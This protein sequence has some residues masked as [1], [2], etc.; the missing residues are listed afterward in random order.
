MQVAR[1]I[2]DHMNAFRL[3]FKTYGIKELDEM[4]HSVAGEGARISTAD[5]ASQFETCMLERG[6]VVFPTVA[7][8]T[9]GYVRIYRAAS[10]IG[11]LLSA[12]R[13]PGPNGDTELARLL[14]T[15]QRRKRPDDLDDDQ[16]G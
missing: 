10:L 5:A 9:E 4:M 1:Q 13:Y 14:T 16:D 7:D 2:T 11:N 6:F 12:F 8:N 3:A 15:L